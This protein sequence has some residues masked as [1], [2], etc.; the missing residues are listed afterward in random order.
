MTPSKTTPK[1]CFLPRLS[2]KSKP[3]ACCNFAKKLLL[4]S[5]QGGIWVT[6]LSRKTIKGNYMLPCSI[7]IGKPCINPYGAPRSVLAESSHPRTLHGANRVAKRTSIITR[8][9]LMFEAPLTMWLMRCLHRMELLARVLLWLRKKLLFEASNDGLPVDGRQRVELPEL[10]IQKLKGNLVWIENQCSKI[11]IFPVASK[12]TSR[13][14]RTGRTY[15]NM[16][17]LPT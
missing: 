5:G 12:A 7:F 14:R 8:G 1:S 4:S 11:L 2:R 17:T 9:R 15:G 10:L 6:F 16:V 13:A 3:S